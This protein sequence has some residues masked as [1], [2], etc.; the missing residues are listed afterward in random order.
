M[1]RLGD[2][3]PLF[4]CFFHD[5]KLECVNYKKMEKKIEFDVIIKNVENSTG[6]VGVNPTRS[7]HCD[8]GIPF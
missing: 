4:L 6:E 8:E 2:E 7:R 5:S 1:N 3:S